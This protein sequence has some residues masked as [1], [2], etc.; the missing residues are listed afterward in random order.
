MLVDSTSATAFNKRIAVRSGSTEFDA[1]LQ[2][3]LHAWGFEV[4]P[5]EAN[6]A[7]LLAGDNVATDDRQQVIRL[8]S[9][10]YHGRDR[11]SLPLQVEELWQTLEH[12]FHRPP[13]MHIRMAIDLPARVTIRGQE[14]TTTLS[15]L[16]D[17]GARIFHPQGSA[18]SSLSPP[19]RCATWAA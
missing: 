7:L 4:C 18:C 2:H 11:L 19:S 8:T 9:S 13:R 6:D 1:V 17:M 12:H 15:S 16:S 14:F 10:H 5:P 3:L